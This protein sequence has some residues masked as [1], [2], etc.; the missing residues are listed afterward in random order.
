MKNFVSKNIFLVMF[1]SMFILN[2][3][4]KD[5][6][7]KSEV[8]TEIAVNEK[9]ENNVSPK[10]KKQADL[11]IFSY[12]RPMQL[13]SFL[14]SIK[15]NVKNLASISVI[16]RV[17]NAEYEIGYELVKEIFNDVRYFKQGNEPAKDFKQFLLKTTFE[18]GVQDYFM[19]GVD[20]II[21]TDEVDVSQCI[22]LLEKEKAYG[23]FLR[24]GKNITSCYTINKK[25]GV[26]AELAQ[27]SKEKDVLGDVFTWCFNK[28]DGDWSQPASTDMTI[29][30]KSDFKDLFYAF[31]FTNPNNF[32][33][34]WIG[35]SDKTKSGLCYETS[36]IV[37][38]PIN[39]VQD[40]KWHRSMNF[41]LPEDLLEIFLD[42]YKIDI[43]DVKASIQKNR[44]E[45]PHMEY[46]LKFIPRIDSILE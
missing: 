12:D 15:I 9:E 24:L 2:L 31:N 7:V 38:I 34:Y 10:E 11:V 16:Y 14:E 17:S 20:D 26:P 44:N 13:Y 45:A 25:C 27:I 23:F 29:Y 33:G 32:E 6:D 43:Q 39:I 21:V 4:A 30:R 46:I 41:L 35:A 22:D 42:G 5:D 8:A 28:S 40:L 18:D 36:Q 19:F 3:N 1:I 37:N